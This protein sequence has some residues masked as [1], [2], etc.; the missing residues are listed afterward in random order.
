MPKPVKD[1]VA[2]NVYLTTAT[3]QKWEDL[4]RRTDIALNRNAEIETAFKDRIQKLRRILG[5]D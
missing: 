3:M 4:Q 1:K 5:K 2:I